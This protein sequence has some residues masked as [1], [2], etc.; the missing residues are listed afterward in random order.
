ML[1]G[2]VLLLAPGAWHPAPAFAQQ[3]QAQQ[4]QPLYA[5]NAKYVNGVAPGYWPTAG[6]G[7]TLNLSP[8]TALCGFPPAP[9]TYTGGTLSMT[10]SVSN[11]VYL[12][13][14]SSCA[15]ASNTTGLTSTTIPI[16]VVLT[17]SSALLR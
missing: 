3:P 8:G 2:L 7:L 5:V 6:T 12:D 16:A 13:T 11:Y 10:A 1:S 4:G 17:G 14:L 9:V 15:P